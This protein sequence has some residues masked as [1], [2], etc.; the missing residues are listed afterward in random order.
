MPPCL[1]LCSAVQDETPTWHR[2]RK[3]M[4]VC[5]STKNLKQYMFGP[6]K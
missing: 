6:M 4:S 1:P 5:F 3:E 2:I